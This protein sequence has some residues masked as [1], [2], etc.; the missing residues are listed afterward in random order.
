MFSF[1][2]LIVVNPASGFTEYDTVINFLLGYKRAK[3]SYNWTLYWYTTHGIFHIGF[4]EL[5]VIG[6][7]L[8]W[9]PPV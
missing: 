7:G 5:V 8:T 6:L 1:C 2:L 4:V 9:A 3:D